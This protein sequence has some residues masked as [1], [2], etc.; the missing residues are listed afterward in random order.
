MQPKRSRGQEG[1]E[2][3]GR[4][5]RSSDTSALRSLAYCAVAVVALVVA[6]AALER[7][8]EATHSVAGGQP[9]VLPPGAVLVAAA[10]AALAAPG[11]AGAGAG[12]GAGAPGA[13]ARRAGSADL[14]VLPPPAAGTVALLFGVTFFLFYVSRFFCPHCFPMTLLLRLKVSI[15]HRMN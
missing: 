8:E 13:R 14:P 7:A 2:E 10:G 1:E 5:E 12:T 11:M 15:S 9:V 6:S 3:A 4:A